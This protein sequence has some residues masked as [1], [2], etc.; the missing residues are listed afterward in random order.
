VSRIDAVPRIKGLAF[1]GMMGSLERMQGV[2]AVHRTFDRLPAALAKT[3]RAE[4]F[5]TQAWYP[6]SDYARLLHAITEATLH[7]LRGVYRILVSMLSPTFLMKRAPMVFNRYYDTGRMVIDAVPGIATARYEG[8]KGFDQLLWN[9]AIY[10]SSGVLEAC[11]AKDVDFRI[12]SGGGDG[13]DGCIVRF[14]WR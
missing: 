8:C 5:V 14:I 7:D 12:V 11:G 1:R 13:D 9:D 2:E 6:L 4:L 3:A 10:G